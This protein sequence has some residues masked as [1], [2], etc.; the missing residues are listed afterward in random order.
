MTGDEDE[1]NVEDVMESLDELKDSI[2]PEADLEPM[3]P[4]EAREHWLDRQE[5]KADSTIR[6][7]KDRTIH[8]IR[9]CDEHGIEDL[10]NITTRHI[11]QYESERMEK[12]VTEST[13]KNEWGTLARMLKH[14]VEL[15]AVLPEI[16][17][18]V[19]VPELSKS[20]RVNTERLP[21]QRALE[22]LENLERFQYASREHVSVMLFWRTTMRLGAVHG[23]DLRDL[24]LEDDDLER[25]RRRLIEDGYTRKVVDG[26]IDNAE[27]P[28]L[29]PRHRPETGTTLKNG[30]EGER[31]INI[32]ESTAQVLEDYISV[33]RADIEDE[34]GRRPLL[35][36]KKGG[37]RLAD[38]SIRNW[39]YVLTQPC[40]FGDPC[41][42]DRDPEE[43][44]AREHGRGNKCPSSMSPH[45]IRTGSYTWHRDK[46]WP[47]R[48]LEEKANTSLDEVYDQPFELNRGMS[49]RQHLD[50]LDDEEGESA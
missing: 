8:F 45:K 20:E 17:E 48:D 1:P 29:F 12:G 31:V 37:G 21:A 30:V 23:L 47:R 36:S 19:D 3:S 7:Y 42:H 33:N 6:S 35:S 39:M 46:G 43:C 11:K 50:R 49:R 4:R 9:F 25:L 38:S 27:T 32:S 28:F 26:V 15:N 2:D 13:K 22:I 14:A 34:H 24:Y 18:A 10:N 41:P 5:E 40:N 44:E 16:P